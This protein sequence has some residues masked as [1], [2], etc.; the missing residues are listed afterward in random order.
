MKDLKKINNSLFFIVSLFL[1]F[2]APKEYSF[3]YCTLILVLF[4]MQN[5][6][7]FK[8]KEYK[9]LASF[10]FFFAFSFCLS[11]F[12]YAVF[13]F[14]VNPDTGTFRFAFNTNVISEA[15]GLSGLGYSSYM[16]ALTLFAKNKSENASK[17][18][19]FVRD[20][21]MLIL[22]VISILSFLGFVMYGGITHLKSVYSGDDADIN[23]IGI[24]SYFFNIYVVTALLL[25]M[26][27]FRMKNKAFSNVVL[28]FLLLC[29][30]AIL[31]TGSRTIV[32]GLTLV[33]MVSYTTF[34]KN[35]ERTQLLL[36]IFLGSILLSLMMMYRDDSFTLNNYNEYYGSGF[37]VYL[38][39][40]GPNRNLY[41]LKDF[42]DNN[43]HVY[44]FSALED[45]ISPIP[46]SS[47]YISSI[48]PFPLDIMAG[49]FP[50]YLEFGSGSSFGLGTNLIG[51]MYFS[52]GVYG[53]IILSFLL[54]MIVR[55]TKDNPN[56]IYSYIIYFLL[57][58]HAVFY[59]R[60]F[61]LFQPR[62]LVWSLLLVFFM[63]KTTQKKCLLF[64]D[65]K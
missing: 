4:L 48:I 7:Y 63:Q 32:V 14:P 25:G 41:V 33:L 1:Y 35:I 49:N 37:D 6:L 58:S 16:L 20:Q 19:F 61:Y 44:F 51:E 53:V 50:T 59:P 12:I 29:M 17:L 39:L 13:Y 18:N 46:G 11:N 22:L 64:Y 2:L 38:D 3:S 24:F 52:F 47:S 23:D 36:I 10:E 56:I 27:V 57:V 21:H 65:K 54:G 60:A 55:K 42:S 30:A 26:F 31:Y 34:I 45:L 8:Q 40:I 43:F 28:L 5:I 15:T 62:I 9:N